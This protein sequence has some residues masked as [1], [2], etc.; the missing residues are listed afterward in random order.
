VVTHALDEAVDLLVRLP[1]EAARQ[2]VLRARPELVQTSLVERLLDQ[3]RRQLQ[4]DRQKSLALATAA[5]TLARQ[6]GDQRLQGCATRAQAN[7]HWASGNNAA[8]VALHEHARSLFAA[9]ADDAELARTL[10]ASIQPLILLGRYDDALR[11]ASQARDL[12]L[13][14]GDHRRLAW[15]EINV[16]N[17]LHRQDRYDEALARYERAYE[18][19]QALGDIEATI[20]ALHNRAV[21][22][23][24]LTRFPEAMAA[25]NAARELC[26]QHQMPLAALQA[27]YNVGWLYYLRGEYARAIDA[28][29]ATLDAAHRAQDRY[30][31]ALCGLDLSEIYLELGLDEDAGELAQQS[32]NRF[33]ELGMGYESAKA[34]VNTALA[35]G[36]EGTPS[37]AMELFDRARALFVAEANYVWPSL[38]DLY[39]AILFVQ[40][41][42][43]AEGRALADAALAFF[44]KTPLSAKV[45]AC[46]LVQARIG[47]RLGELDTAERSCLNAMSQL[48]DLEMPA[49]SFEAHLLL[50]QV[51]AARA[52]PVGAFNSYETARRKLDLLR[53]RVRG[54][55]LKIAFARDKL[56]LYEHLVS[57]CLATTDRHQL[58]EAFGYVE[59]AKSRIL[60]EFIARLAPGFAA[61]DEEENSTARQ[62]RELRES[63]NWYYRTLETEQLRPSDR[64][65]ERVQQLQIEVRAREKQ[66]ARLLR[67]LPASATAPLE[68]PESTIVALEEIRDALPDDTVLLEYF[69]VHD[70]MLLWLVSRADLKVLTLG[71]VSNLRRRVRRLQFQ[72]GKFQLGADYVSTFNTLLLA[73]VRASLRSLHRELLEAVWPDL[74]GKHVL[75][76][77]HDFLHCVP[78]HA[79]C[80]DTEYVIDRCTVSYAPSASVYALTRRQRP[81]AATGSLVLAVADEHAPLIEAEA[82]EVAAVLPHSTLCLGPSATSSRLRAAGPSTEVIHI[83]SHGYFR[84]DRPMFS[85][86]RLADGHL[87]VHDL[88]R[89]K[90]PAM[91]VTLSGCATG[92]TLSAGEEIL[93]MCRGLF[94]A[95]ARSL[96][97]SLWHI[98]DASTTSFM[99][100][101]YE[102]L[103][104][105]GDL[106]QAARDAMLRVRAQHPNPYYWAPFVVMGQFRGGILQSRVQRGNG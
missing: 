54:D 75:I 74:D 37:R 57:L 81:S 82:R 69:Q 17:I 22:L 102:R 65:A 26:L 103:L 16:G 6:L 4:V 92:Q 5:E 30:H 8:A 80:T 53:G 3:A 76:V 85:A 66:L 105:T 9:L 10:N 47:L 45:A 86:I 89:L 67:E 23:T 27:D 24:S 1:D 77:P 83:A 95:G 36:R 7:A 64:T 40:Q 106:A 91:L 68:Q 96:L 46:H 18:E 51:Q 2:A 63:L 59:Q 21:T 41:G 29:H 19:V 61:G 78:F 15:L 52:N 28:L 55:E 70:R 14:L 87:T 48:V 79:L 104:D 50:G 35:Y 98:H 31:A 93:G 84:P 12:F 73:S 56:E 97:L 94:C 33:R 100:A 20:S 49:L 90:L 101:F 44:L 32:H 42:R 71:R 99:T 25:Y 72:L 43:L 88:S 38:I 11:S 60:L 62:I 13:T 39:Q 58:E 34:L